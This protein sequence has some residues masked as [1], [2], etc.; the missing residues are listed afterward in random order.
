MKRTLLWI[1]CLA[2]SGQVLQ[3]QNQPSEAEIKAEMMRLMQTQPELLN[4]PEQL[5]EV[6][7]KNLGVKDPN[8]GEKVKDEGMTSATHSRYVEKVAFAN[9]P[10]SKESPSESSFK[11]SFAS[12]AEGIY[13]RV[14][15]KESCK[16][17]L[18]N[19]GGGKDVGSMQYQVNYYINGKL[20]GSGEENIEREAALTATT[21]DFIIAP[22]TSDKDAPKN[23]YNATSGFVSAINELP[24]GT[25]K[26]KVE[27][28]I[29][30][31]KTLTV[32]ASSEFSLTLTTSSRDA[33][34]DAFYVKSAPPIYTNTNNNST[35]N[36]SNNGSCEAPR[37]TIDN[38]SGKTITVEVYRSGSGRV[39]STSQYGGKA[40]YDGFRGTTIKINGSD[41]KT[42]TDA[43]NGKTFIY[44]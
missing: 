3:A 18:V 12:P 30:W 6:A 39:L 35:N 13:A 2:W 1:F 22:K 37:I 9:A 17:L 11:T 26:I 44:K 19:A 40:N 21:F 15:A 34:V 29:G 23:N 20:E 4:N 28:T 42:L 5:I 16:N 25:H 27:V 10:I 31:D 41:F 32:L 14:Y 24:A 8:V 33:F 43:D 38:Q 7:R 36:T